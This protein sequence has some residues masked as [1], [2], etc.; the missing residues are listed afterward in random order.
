MLHQL[1][2]AGRKLSARD[3]WTTEMRRLWNATKRK[4][5]LMLTEQT[6]SSLD[7]EPIGHRLRFLVESEVRRLQ[8]NMHAGKRAI[9][10]AKQDNLRENYQLD[11]VQNA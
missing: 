9:T 11:L 7:T 1:L 2:N 10:K 8:R 4:H 5:A 3:N 6:K